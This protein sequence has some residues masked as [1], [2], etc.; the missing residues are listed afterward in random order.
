MKKVLILVNSENSKHLADRAIEVLEKYSIPYQLEVTSALKQQIHTRE[1]V[2]E[3]EA[4][5]F[6]CIAGLSDPLPG[7]VASM[8]PK[9]VIGV[10]VSQKLNGLD[11]LLSMAQMPAGIPVATVGIDNSKN[12]AYLALRV[13]ALKYPEIISTKPEPTVSEYA[14]ETPAAMA[15]F[16]TSTK[17]EEPVTFEETRTEKK[18]SKGNWW[19]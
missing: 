3:S 18:R 2:K 6:I 19:M 10:P 11:A 7:I 16:M 14:S 15:D 13:L 4:D 17:P 1:L 9:P 12:A 5:V 8:T